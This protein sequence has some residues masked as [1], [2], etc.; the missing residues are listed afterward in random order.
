MKQALIDTDTLSYFF[1]N[2]PN[3]VEKL[4][5]YLQEF[6]FVN[7]SVVTYYEVLNGLYFKDAK[8]QLAKFEQFVELNQVLPLTD[9]IAKKAA[10]IYA[11]LRKKGMTVGHND[12]MIA[13]TA[14]INN[15]T[16]VTNNT[17]HYEKIDD[18]EM[19][20]WSF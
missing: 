20:N 15:M 7:I 18:L 12:M 13:C 1:R 5:K 9:E 17:K 6:G 4:D 8:G 14:I 11:N 19:D 16:L 10:E 2:N 3:V